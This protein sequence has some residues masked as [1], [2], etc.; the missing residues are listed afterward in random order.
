M[1]YN[2]DV[3]D[4][5]LRVVFHNLYNH[6]PI[7]PYCLA[8]VECSKDKTCIGCPDMGYIN[9]ANKVHRTA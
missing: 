7:A 4:F 9:F 5:M 1:E 8:Y 3:E 6:G 2:Y